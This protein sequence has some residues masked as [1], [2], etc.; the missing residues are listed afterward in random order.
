MRKLAVLT[1]VVAI[2]ALACA[3]SSSAQL[4]R[5]LRMRRSAPP[6]DAL[7]LPASKV[8]TSPVTG[9]QHVLVHT[10][11]FFQ[12]KEPAPLAPAAAGSDDYVPSSAPQR[13]VAK[14]SV[15][16]AKLEPFA[17]IDDLRKSL[18]ADAVMQKHNPRI[19]KATDFDRVEEEKRNVSVTA[20]IY[21]ISHEG[22]NDFHVIIGGDLDD[23]DRLYMNVEVAGLPPMD[24]P[25]RPALQ[26]A[27]DQFK[28]YFGANLPGP[29]FHEAKPPIPVQVTGS[30]FYDISHPPDA[31]GPKAHKPH[32]AWEIHPVTDIQ[33]LN[34]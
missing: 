13:L 11:E 34:K 33:F 16:T 32:T 25:F 7:A 27:R 23:P 2:A 1:L 18:P 14:L 15:A 12:S 28:K 22:D 29:G 4:L 17:H 10:G 20:Y 8:F 3:D 26:K 19:T 5:R 6:P 31:P 9:K 24:S 21:A 30:L